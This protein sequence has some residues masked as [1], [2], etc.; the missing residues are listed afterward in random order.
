M[1]KI[2]LVLLLLSSVSVDSQAQSWADMLKSLFGMST[3]KSEEIIPETT[4]IKASELAKTWLFSEPVIDYTGSD[5]VATMAVSALEGQ[6]EGLMAKAG[7]Q[8]GRDRVTFKTNKT[9]T[10]EINGVVAMGNYTYNPSTGEITMS[11]SM[12]EKTATLSG[13]TEY[14]NG[15]LKLVFDA[16]HVLS[17]M[18]AA[19]PS[20]ADHDYVKIAS[21]VIDTYPGIR[22]GG[23]FK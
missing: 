18:K 2:L 23:T 5:P 3:K 14:E 6:M 9:L 15:V 17:T 16:N 4:H 10:I 21:S 20:L 7:I 11:V 12:K 13:Q 1:K 8:S 22:L 19:A